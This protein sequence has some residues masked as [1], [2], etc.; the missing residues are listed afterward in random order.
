MGSRVAFAVP[1]LLIFLL[2]CGGEKP[3]AIVEDIAKAAPDKVELLFENASVSVMRV[4]LPSQARLPMHRGRDRLI[5]S[6]TNYKLRYMGPATEPVIRDFKPGD[7]QWRPA[8]AQAVQ[9]VGPIPAR[10]LVVSRKA[11]NP[12]PGVTSNIA[13]LAPDKARVVFENQEAKVIEI[14]LQP[15]DKLPPH[16]AA[17][18]VIYSLTP[19]KIRFTAAGKSMEEEWA[20]GS[21]HWHDG[22]EHQ[23]ENLSA[24]PV[25]FLVFELM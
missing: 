11:N 24:E 14:S 23:V 25:R 3:E 2:S 10:Y 20:E 16:T 9:N 5:Y 4:T 17:G 12:T 7:V 13:E 15:K 18:R 1:F 8:G 6:L 19:A 21:V 22:G